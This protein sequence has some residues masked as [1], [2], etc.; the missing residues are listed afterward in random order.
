MSPDVLSA[1][2]TVPTV[3]TD[4]HTATG[5]LDASDLSVTP[6]A[7]TAP[8][9]Q[10]AVAPAPVDP[11]ADWSRV[12]DELAAMSAQ[13]GPD[14]GGDVMDR[15][16]RWSPPTDLGRLPAVLVDRALEVLAGHA[17]VV[18]HLHEALA[19][20]RRHVR[21]LSAVPTVHDAPAAAY[22]DVQA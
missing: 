19:E 17:H 15:L 6:E 5:T 14:A 22:L 4:L 16:V 12:L 20:N 1:V 10:D 13:A 9:A 8:A 3:P 21:A 7:S 2:P 18:E 11:H